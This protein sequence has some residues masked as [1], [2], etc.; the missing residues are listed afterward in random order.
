MILVYFNGKETNRLHYTLRHLL[1]N[2]LGA[3]FSIISDKKKFSKHDGP[4]INYSEDTSL[5]GIQIIP[6][7][8]LSEKGV[9]ARADMKISQWKGLFVFFHTGQS[10]IPFDLFAASFYLLTLYEEHFPK[11]LDKHGR[12]RHDES[13]LYRNGVLEIPV[14]DRWAYFLKEELDRAGYNTSPF[15]LRKFQ[16]IGTYDID[17]PFMYRNKG[18]IKN[19][20]GIFKDLIKGN[21]KAVKDR[22]ITQLHLKE[23]PYLKAL[24]LINEIQKKLN[25]PYY[26]FILLGDRGKYGITTLYSP[27]RYYNYIKDLESVKIGL[28]PSYNSFRNLEQLMKE[29]TE[30]ENILGYPVDCSRQHFL[31]M[32]SPETFQELNMIGIKEDFTLAFAQVPGFR[33][34]TAIPYH[35]YDIRKDEES[36]LLIHPTVMMD[37]TLIFHQ[38]LTPEQAL[39]KIKNLIDECKKSGGD[40]LSLWHNSNLVYSPQKNPW[41]SVFI[42]SYKYAIKV[43]S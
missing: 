38:N 19:T 6:E 13:L 24:M 39:K 26:L 3:E 10:V 34:G 14:I 8:L 30:L 16:T 40:Y 41:I 27:Q 2:I 15:A 20:A 7:G 43:E 17:Y 1:D 35:F 31:R 5:P 11:E 21:F 9:K 23:D 33:S 36:Q 4:Q 29:K 32:Q 25:K 37:S 18:V 12:F 28:H 22:T 42:H